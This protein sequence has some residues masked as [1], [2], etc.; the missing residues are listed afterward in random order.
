M[1]MWKW[2]SGHK[3][4]RPEG[5]KLTYGIDDIPPLAMSLFLG[6]QHYLTMVGATL[7]IPLILADPLGVKDPA[8][9]AELMSTIFFMSGV[10]TLLQTTGTSACPP[11]TCNSFPNDAE[12]AA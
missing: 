6:L 4:P 7:S 5:S 8:D 11:S 12:N 9:V 10:V 2:V 3:N 1:S